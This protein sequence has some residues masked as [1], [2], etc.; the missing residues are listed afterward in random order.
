[1]P[2]DTDGKVSKRI[3]SH[4]L[5]SPAIYSNSTS[6]SIAKLSALHF[7][8]SMDKLLLYRLVCYPELG[9]QTKTLTFHLPLGF[10]FGGRSHV[11]SQGIE[12]ST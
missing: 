1:M 8:N 11:K 4:L 3:V 9:P 7:I 6:F 5:I 10:V 12:L 2:R